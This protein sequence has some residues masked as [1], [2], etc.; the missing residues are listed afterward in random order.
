MNYCAVV[1][2]QFREA[3][4]STVTLT[5]KLICKHEVV[6][7]QLTQL[8]FNLNEMWLY[9]LCMHSLTVGEMKVTDQTNSA[10]QKPTKSH[11]ST[12]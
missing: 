12:V 10:P 8:G 11:F 9:H 6:P 2:F 1:F 4:P 5:V 7:V 3:L